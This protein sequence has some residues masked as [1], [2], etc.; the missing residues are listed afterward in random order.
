MTVKKTILCVD[1]EQSLSIQKVTLE[2][3]GYRVMTC[4]T[5]VEAMNIF[6]HG[7][8]DLVMSNVDLPDAPATDLVGH[9]KALSPEI[10]V[11]LLSAQIR[12]FQTDAPVDLLLR[13]GTYAPAE[14]LERIRLLLMKR[15]GPRR[16]VPPA[17]TGRAQA[18]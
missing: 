6:G 17:I 9:I 4:N 18:C 16:A 12:A 10:P 5:A 3:R 11:I 8:V 2:T 1:D 15:R 7:S 14:L 13:K